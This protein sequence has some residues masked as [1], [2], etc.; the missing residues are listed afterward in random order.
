MSCQLWDVNQ[1]EPDA[2][3]PYAS[4]ELVQTGDRCMK[5]D[6]WSAGIICWQLCTNK[7]EIPF[8][9][10][11]GD[12]ILTLSLM[13]SLQTESGTLPLAA[14]SCVIQSSASSTLVSAVQSMLFLKSE[15][16]ATISDVLEQSHILDDGG[17]A[18][19]AAGDYHL[20]KTGKEL[21]GGS[22]SYN[23]IM[24]DVLAKKN[25][26]RITKLYFIPDSNSQTMLRLF[27]RT[28]SFV[29]F[30]ADASSW[31]RILQR[32]IKLTDG[33]EIILDDFPPIEVQSG[34]RTA[35]F[36]HTE[37]SSGIL[38]YAES[39]G[40]D[41]RMGE[42]QEENADIAISVGKKCESSSP[43][44]S[45]QTPKRYFKGCI[46]Y[47]LMLP[48]D[49]R[50]STLLNILA[51][52]AAPT[53]AAPAE[54]NEPVTT[55]SGND[56]YFGWGC[57]VSVS[58]ACTSPAI[59]E[60]WEGF[61]IRNEQSTLLIQFENGK[62][63]WVPQSK[64]VAVPDLPAVSRSSCIRLDSRQ[65]Y[66]TH[67]AQVNPFYHPKHHMPLRTTSKTDSEGRI[68]FVTDLLCC[69]GTVLVVGGGRWSVAVLQSDQIASDL[70]SSSKTNTPLLLPKASPDAEEVAASPTAP[71]TT[72]YTQIPPPSIVNVSVDTRRVTCGGG[73]LNS[74]TIV[75]NNIAAAPLQ[76]ILRNDDEKYVGP[77]KLCFSYPAL[78]GVTK[79]IGKSCLVWTA[80]KPTDGSLFSISPVLGGSCCVFAKW[81]AVTRNTAADDEASSTGT[82]VSATHISL[83]A[84]TLPQFDTR[85]RKI[86]LTASII[87]PI[88]PES[89]TH[90]TAIP[91]IS[92]DHSPA[93]FA[94]INVARFVSKSI[95][96]HTDG[97]ISVDVSLSLLNSLRS[98]DGYE[99]SP[100][101]AVFQLSCSSQNV[102]IQRNG[103]EAVQSACVPST[104]T[105]GFPSKKTRSTRSRSFSTSKPNCSWCSR[106]PTGR[107]PRLCFK[108][109]MAA[110]AW[111]PRRRHHLPR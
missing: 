3:S 7:Y 53:A 89:D 38:F 63:L 1:L 81:E 33:I 47:E 16:R 88:S 39:D 58:V 95:L 106:H 70:P 50:R 73:A 84:A 59:D 55:I 9:V 107:T 102:E 96:C 44:A 92:W 27:I 2:A 51:R 15:K 75:A 110:V 72:N 5:G 24:F 64:L 91:V 60:G 13:D 79:Q 108:H 26:L 94:T 21:R 25:P 87:S 77:P 76:L 10:A 68:M 52:A 28:G 48:K 20:F 105:T 35:I 67:C 104:I 23:G 36:L 17:T 61:V 12:P 8:E 111:C 82:A 6:V 85:N 66:L 97:Q 99:D 30:E 37:N 29:G 32:S 57:R 86:S 40:V 46:G 22:G 42:M 56:G 45:V 103:L 49:K 11:D 31:V 69:Q 65:Y 93:Q 100:H 90:S 83:W 109:S 80:I 43:F 101:N 34:Q 71:T 14:D 4:P 74:P 19:N 41:A 78:I 54:Q 98:G 18:A 62:K